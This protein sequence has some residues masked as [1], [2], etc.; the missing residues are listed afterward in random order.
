M[1][2]A[3]M[4]LKVISKKKLTDK[5]GWRQIQISHNVDK[6]VQILGKTWIELLFL[7]NSRFQLTPKRKEYTNKQ[8]PWVD[9]YNNYYNTTQTQTNNP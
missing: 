3:K 1:L 2:I 6:R 8:V 4:L 9:R 5:F 7:T